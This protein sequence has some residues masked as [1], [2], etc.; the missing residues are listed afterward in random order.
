[1]ETLRRDAYVTFAWRSYPRDPDQIW[2][3]NSYPESPEHFYAEVVS[4]PSN[5]VVR[6]L[7]NQ[8]YLKQSPEDIERVEYIRNYFQIEEIGK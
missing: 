1:M 7:S 2:K 3:W 6:D 8:K 4:C 5:A